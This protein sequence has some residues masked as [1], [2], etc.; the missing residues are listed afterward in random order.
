MGV[1]PNR[2]SGQTR[3]PSVIAILLLAVVTPSLR[4]G[5]RLDP[6]GE[7]FEPAKIL[8]FRHVGS[9]GN[10]SLMNFTYIRGMQV[11]VLPHAIII[12]G[13]TGRFTS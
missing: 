4:G 10:Q 6:S 2:S 1:F 7:A 8:N 11:E 13:K 9:L 3:C 12:S 5:C